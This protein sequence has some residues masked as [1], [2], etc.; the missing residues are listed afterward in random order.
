MLPNLIKINQLYAKGNV[1]P[2]KRK[3]FRA[4][5]FCSVKDV[6]VC[7]L[8][9]DPYHGPGQANGLAFSVD[10]DVRLPPSLKNIYKELVDDIGCKMPT[11]GDLTAWAEQGVLLLNTALTVEA[12]KPGSHLDLW[13]DFIDEV[14]QELVKEEVLFVVWG[15]KAEN[16]LLSALGTQQTT[17]YLKSSHPSP[18]SAHKGFFGSKPFSKINE[19]LEKEGK[20]PIKWNT[21]EQ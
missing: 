2:P 13:S 21:L 12:G 1:Y 5:E 7:I 17:R 11:H 19:I 10:K 6:K 3:I 18:Y 20:E 8:G 15:N 4:L 14:I 16:R 9:Q